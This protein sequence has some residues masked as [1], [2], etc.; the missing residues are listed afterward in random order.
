[1]WRRTLSLAANHRLS[2]LI[3]HRVVKDRDPLLPELPTGLDF[4]ALLLHLTRRFSILPLAEAVDRLY[5]RTLPSAALSITFDDGYA[6][7]L[8]VAAPV[9]RKHNA[10]ATLFIATGYLDGG[11]MWNDVVIAAIRSAT[12]PDI[13]LSGLRLGTFRLSSIEARRRA[14]DR[15]LAEL[16]YRPFAVRERD[17]RAILDIAGVQL[18]VSPMMTSDGVRG[19]SHLGIDIGAHTVSH[20]ILARTSKEEAWREITESKQALERLSGRAVR[21][22]AYPNGRPGD[23]Y[24]IEHVTMVREAGFE[25]AVSTGWGAAS[26]ASDAMQL[27]RFTPWS[28]HA[29]KFDLLMLRNLA[30]ET[31]EVKACG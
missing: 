5:A 15:I 30:R 31:D 28:R 7:N 17:A 4:D 6:D 21:L 10:S 14:I 1:M 18:P 29:F 3:F 26:P 27:P 2:I 24:G 22:F 11:T 12:R 13:D 23:D 16:K 20:P 19:L 9:L 25:A 8:V